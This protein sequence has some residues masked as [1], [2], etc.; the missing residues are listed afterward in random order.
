ML[1]KSHVY[2]PPST[3]SVWTTSKPKKIWNTTKNH[4]R[5]INIIRSI[6]QPP[7]MFRSEFPAFFLV[8]SLVGSETTL[9]RFGLGRSIGHRQ[10][11]G[12]GSRALRWSQGSQLWSVWFFKKRTINFGGVDKN[13]KIWESRN[14]K[15][16]N[17]IAHAPGTQSHR[18]LVQIILHFNWMIFRFYLDFQV[19]K[20]PWLV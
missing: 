9:G 6:H 17:F 3:N 5:N 15:V 18:G 14:V 1:L 12:Q 10:I 8:P 19:K 4:P 16:H 11:Q 13:S 7:K 2:N 20:H